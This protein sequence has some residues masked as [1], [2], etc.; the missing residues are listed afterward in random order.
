MKLFMKYQ[1]DNAKI[2]QGQVHRKQLVI[3]K[4]LEQK[5]IFV[6]LLF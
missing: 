5:K 6:K 4:L 2:R 1:R 3:A